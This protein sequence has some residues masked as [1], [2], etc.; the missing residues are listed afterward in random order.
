MANPPP[1]LQLFLLWILNETLYNLFYSSDRITQTTNWFN[2][3][4]RTFSFNKI[5]PP[6]LN[7]RPTRWYWNLLWTLFSKLHFSEPKFTHYATSKVINLYF[8]CVG[9]CTFTVNICC[10]NIKYCQCMHQTWI[11]L[12]VVN[13]YCFKLPKI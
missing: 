8:N 12:Y 5:F 11:V 4:H 2:M 13:K 3:V 1:P 10:T 7:C 9:M 6:E